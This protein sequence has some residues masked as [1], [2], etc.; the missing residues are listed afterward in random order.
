MQVLFRRSAG[1]EAL[2]LGVIGKG[3]GVGWGWGFRVSTHLALGT[4][5]S[6][7]RWDH[8]LVRVRVG[9]GLRVRLRPRLRL[10]RRRRVRL[11]LR[12]RGAGTTAAH[13]PVMR[14]ADL[15]GGSSTLISS[16]GRDSERRRA[17]R[18]GRPG[19]DI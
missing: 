19:T 9:S 18:S 11:R 1:A 7:R 3:L 14:M 4:A 2:W 15:G 13:R 6:Q 5:L 17:L 8:G 10:R 12:V 16:E